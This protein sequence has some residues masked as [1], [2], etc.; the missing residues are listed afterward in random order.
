M[1]SSGCNRPA[2]AAHG[3]ANF[4]GRAREGLTCVSRRG[5]LKAGL[6]GIAGLSLPELLRS[7]ARAAESGRPMASR[8]SIILLWMA[9]GPSQIDTLDPKPGRPYENRGPFGVISTKLP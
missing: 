7:R 9:G 3:F 5:M 4:Y 8:K 2:H 6:A 1:F